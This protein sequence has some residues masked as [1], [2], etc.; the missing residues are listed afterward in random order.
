M[1]EW[2]KCIE[3]YKKLTC[4]NKIHMYATL[5]PPEP[6][7]GIQFFNLNNPILS[8]AKKI[9]AWFSRK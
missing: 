9:L 7:S 3:L 6:M 8:Y 4:L 2:I 1:Y 5:F